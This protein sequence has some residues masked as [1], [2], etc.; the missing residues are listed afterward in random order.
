MADREI[1]FEAADNSGSVKIANEVIMTIASQ[2]VCDIKGVTVAST[3]AEGIVDM[4]VKKNTQRGVRI[5]TN[6]ETGITDIDVHINVTYGLK[7]LEV[8]W[9]VQQAVKKNVTMMTDVKLGNV[10]VFVDGIIV[11]KEP[12][13]EKKKEEKKEK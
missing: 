12:K 11:E 6:E 2:A 1:I 4:I 5:L 7:I 3:F 10:N 13:P 8:S 9:A